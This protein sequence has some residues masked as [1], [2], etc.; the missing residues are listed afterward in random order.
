MILFKERTMY[1]SVV[2]CYILSAM[3]NNV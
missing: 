2:S 3:V 1:S